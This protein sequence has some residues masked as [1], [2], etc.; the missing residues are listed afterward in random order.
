MAPDIAEVTKSGRAGCKKCGEKI[1]M[2]ALRVGKVIE[3]GDFNQVKWYHPACWPVTRALAC[4]DELSGWEALTLEQQGE[5]IARAPEK[6][7]SNAASTSSSFAPPA[8]AGAAPEKAPSTAASTSSSSAPP[9]PAGAGAAFEGFVLMCDRVGAVSSSKEKSAT[10]RAY[11]APQTDEDAYL[12]VRLLLPSKAHDHRS[13]GLKEKSL[14]AH[15]STILRCGQG[16]MESHFE[17]SGCVG[18]TAQHFFERSTVAAPAPPSPRLVLADVDRFLDRLAAAGAGAARELLGQMLRRCSAPELR[19]L[20]RVIGKDARLR[21]GAAVV[22]AALGPHAHDAYRSAPEK[23]RQIVVEHRSGAE[24][25]AAS[26]SGG[27]GAGGSGARACMVPFKPQLAG[28]CGAFE[29]AEKKF[30]GGFLVEVKYDGERV[31]AHLKDGG[32][33]FWSRALK[34]IDDHKVAGVA[35]ALGRAFPRAAELIVDGEVVMVSAGGEILPFGAQGK[36]KQKEHAGASCCLFV[37]DLLWWNGADLTQLP[38]AE[39]RARLERE[40]V[41][42]PSAPGTARVEA[43]ACVTLRRASQLAAAFR[44]CARRGLEGLMIKGC[45]SAYKPE[46]RKAWLKMKKDYLGEAQAQEAGVAM[47]DSVDLVLLGG[48]LGKKGNAGK[49][50]IFLMGVR[51]EGHSPS[52]SSWLSVCKVGSPCSLLPAPCSLLPAPRHTPRRTPRGSPCAR[53][54]TASPTSG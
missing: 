19:V 32:A 47:A 8:P 4:L 53:W 28:Q 27:G 16:A 20:L 7:P 14:L 35:A 39:R 42:H 23:L 22:L 48:Y 3:G 41:P 24:P 37:F 11:L 29:A 44:E 51:A 49:L 6:A 26:S 13:Y 33:R 15:L 54:A 34:P 18:L 21:A 45:A 10:I 52:H 30:G 1:A 31:Q 36:H 5:L 50:S 25:G 2:G 40:L 46:D 17:T 12:A 9:A 38:Q 43:S